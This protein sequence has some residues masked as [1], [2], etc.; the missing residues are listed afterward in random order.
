MTIP[1][2]NVTVAPGDVE[3]GAKIFKT[4]CAQCHNADQVRGMIVRLARV[5]AVFFLGV[6]GGAWKGPC[7]FRSHSDGHGRFPE[8]TF[9]SACMISAPFDAIFLR[10]S[11]GWQERPGP[12]PLGHHRSHL[13]IR[14]WFRVLRGQQELGHRVERQALGSISAGSQEGGSSACGQL[15]FAKRRLA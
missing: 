9:A 2:P 5:H 12:Q 8:P 3:K 7:T 11:T 15:S 10:L 14:R 1:E 4:K 6:G 13:W